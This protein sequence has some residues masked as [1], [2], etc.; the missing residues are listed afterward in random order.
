M[1]HVWSH[2]SR[3]IHTTRMVCCVPLPAC[4]AGCLPACVPAAS[5]AVATGFSGYLS[6]LIK[7]L[8]LIG[9]NRCA[10]GLHDFDGSTCTIPCVFGGSR[11]AAGLSKAVTVAAATALLAQLHPACLACVHVSHDM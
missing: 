11:H 7:N 8:D 2:L 10:R 1:M 4:L 9:P 5:A 3:T 6:A